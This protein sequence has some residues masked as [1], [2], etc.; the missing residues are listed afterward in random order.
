M[1][2]S[3]ES[4][5]DYQDA[6]K[7]NTELSSGSRWSFSGRSNNDSAPS[8]WYYEMY[9]LE[10]IK[11]LFISRIESIGF[12]IKKVNALYANGQSHGQCGNYHQDSK[13]PGNLT[14]LYYANDIWHP[15]WGGATVFLNERKEP[16]ES[17]Y[18]AFNKAIIFDSEIFHA[19]LEPT[20]LFKGLR[21]TVAFKF[22]GY[23]ISR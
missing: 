5:F 20:S 18:P 6:I 10:E 15:A 12:N 23:K 21:I 7:V 14:L 19:G 4:F 22:N 8:F 3:I 9:D 13:I 2:L 16:A 11:S 17:S 1:L